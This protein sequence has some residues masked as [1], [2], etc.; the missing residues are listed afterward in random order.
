VFIFIFSQ[1]YFG[2]FTPGENLRVNRYA[3]DSFV[4]IVLVRIT[5]MAAKKTILLADDD[6]NDVY[7]VKTA[8]KR[9]G[10]DFPFSVVPNGE[11]A[12][13]YLKGTGKYA[14]RSKYPIPALVLLD[15]KMP[16]IDGF[17]VLRWVRSHPEW[18]AL[19]IIVLT[20][21]YYGPDINRAY[22][23]GANSFLT[24][25]GDF[26]DYVGAVKQVAH[27]WLVQNVSPELG[28]FVALPEEQTIESGKPTPKVGNASRKQM[29]VSRSHRE[30]EQLEPKHKPE[31][32]EPS[33]N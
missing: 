16:S 8:F 10:Y 11:E 23:L 1:N 15:L 25:P 20:N 17:D 30:P 4:S 7:I 32:G 24:K 5:L 19:P 12:I 6:P 3:S 33:P 14:N 18:K 2:V 27:F 29:R 28:P 9:A 21:S 13:A 31:P 22:D 26:Y